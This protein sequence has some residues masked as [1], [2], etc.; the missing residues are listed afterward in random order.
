MVKYFLLLI[1]LTILSCSDEDEPQLGTWNQ[2]KDVP[3]EGRS[4]GLSFSLLGK[5]YLVSGRN[6]GNLHLKDVW[7]YD[8]ATD[9][10]TQKKDYPFIVSVEHVATTG[11]KA[12]VIDYTG[13]LYEYNPV[14]DSW[15]YLS[16]FPTGA[17][18]GL[19][20]F[21]LDGNVYFGTGNGV[22]AGDGYY[23]DFWKYD[24]SKNQWAQIDDFPG[25]PRSTAFSFVI[26]DHAYVGL[27]SSAGAPPIH[28]DVYRY[29]AKT[30]KWDQIADLP[31]INSLMG[32]SFS[33][34]SK[35]YIGLEERN[36]AKIYEYDPSTD[37][38][39]TLTKFPSEFSVLTNSFTINNRMF[40]FG[41]K[42][43][44]YG[45]HLW[46]FIP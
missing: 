10:W 44:T 31:E 8:P 26:G 11:D 14:L 45:K 34:N 40:V 30:G 46:E 27:G 39:R 19:T 25:Q 38:W 41:G 2:L 7:S 6:V 16:T 12:Y 23:N 5:G 36:H 42:A 9:S 29:S 4:Y 28:P 17:R 33:N 35:G 32:L 43:S 13:K 1:S 21:G 15:R 3:Y 18:P 20:G 22:T 24:L 37:S